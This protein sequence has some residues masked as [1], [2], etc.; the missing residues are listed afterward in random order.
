MVTQAYA[1]EAETPAA[2]HAVDAAHGTDAAHGDPTADTHAT[3]EAH[4]GDH[5]SGVFPPFDPATFPSQLVW[6]AITFAALYV[7]LSKVALPRIGGILEN[8]KALI[9]ADLAAADADRQKTD[10]AIA[11][12]EKALADAKSNAQGI[13]NQTRDAIQADLAVKRT[14]VEADLSAKVTAAEA[15]IAQTKA[16]ALTHVDEIAAETAQAVVGQ[17]VGDVSA[18]SV[19]AAVAKVKG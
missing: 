11:A 2:E 15:R 13:A 12:Y 8:R 5:G 7:L 3:T 16:E 9:D 17:I 1:Q 14:A 18:D 4:G 19:R 6:L 10:A